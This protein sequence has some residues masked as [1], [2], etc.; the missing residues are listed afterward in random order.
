MNRPC[1]AGPPVLLPARA[2]LRKRAAGW[3]PRPA[4]VIAALFPLAVGCGP[5][6]PPSERDQPKAAR[7]F[8]G[9]AA[10]AHDTTA[11]STDLGGPTALD[12]ASL[13]EVVRFRRARVA[14]YESLGIFPTPY[15]PLAGPARHIWDRLTPGAAWLGPTPYYVANPYVLV[16]LTCA[17]H[18]TPIDLVCPD[19]ELTYESGRFVERHRGENARCWL[20]RVWSDACADAPGAIRVIM[21]NAFDAGFPFAH[22]DLAASANVAAGEGPRNIGRSIH[23]QP[24]YFHVGRYGV[25]NI[26]PQDRDGWLAVGDP[27]A[28]TRIVVKLWRTRPSSP[29]RPADFTYEIHVDP[30]V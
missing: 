27:G 5:G 12:G 22:V 11:A 30:S 24:C 21:L 16:V 13:D 25:T 1:D 2:V 6:E 7:L 3:R 20:S 4:W 26:S 28:A 19:L 17:N 18:V 14:A 10:I 15:D 9:R 29:A 8:H 23:S